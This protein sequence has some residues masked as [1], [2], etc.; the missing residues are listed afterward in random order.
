MK[1]L[2]INKNQRKK[3]YYFPLESVLINI[4]ILRTFFPSGWPVFFVFVSK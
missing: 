4:N 1:E 3:I 2:I